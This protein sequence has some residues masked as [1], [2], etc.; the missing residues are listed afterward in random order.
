MGKPER[1]S[2]QHLPLYILFFIRLYAAWRWLNEVETCSWVW[3]LIHVI[4]LIMSAYE[5]AKTG[6]ATSNYKTVA[7]RIY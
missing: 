5:H 6:R 7:G 1:M 3:I 2:C 4:R